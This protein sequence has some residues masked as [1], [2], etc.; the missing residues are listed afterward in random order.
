MRRACPLHFVQGDS[1]TR[2]RPYS[3]YGT[4]MF[5]TWVACSRN[6]SPSP[7]RASA[8]SRSRPWST[9]VRF[10]LPGGEP[11]HLRATLRGAEVPDPVHVVVRREHRRELLADAGHDVHHPA[12]QVGGVEH[13]VQVGGGKR[14][15]DRRNR[16]HRVPHRDGRQ[17]GRH[18]A[19]AA[20]AAP[21]R[22]CRARRSARA[23][24]GSR[25]GR[26]CGGPRRRTCRP[27]RRRCRSARWRAP[28]PAPRRRHRR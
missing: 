17:H 12:R 10:M 24:R 16:D 21:G 27:R 9:Q 5:F 13:L 8:Q 4:Q 18:E 1:R 23:S 22:R 6:S 19:P 3:P 7:C 28:P 20:A 25:C 11:L 2:P 15:A 14:S 26:A